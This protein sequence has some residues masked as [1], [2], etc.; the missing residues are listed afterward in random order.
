MLIKLA[1]IH[2]IHYVENIIYMY[3]LFHVS[4]LYGC[5]K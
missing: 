3:C 1:Y 2:Y 4:V 5:V